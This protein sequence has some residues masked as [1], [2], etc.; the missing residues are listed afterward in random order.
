MNMKT[1]KKNQS[2]EAP[3]DFDMFLT[4]IRGSTNHQ[5]QRAFLKFL[6]EVSVKGQ[7]MKSLKWMK[8]QK[9]TKY[10]SAN[11]NIC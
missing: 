9:C 2:R 10:S 4:A 6:E 5:F 1:F 7:G 3:V 11:I 8:E